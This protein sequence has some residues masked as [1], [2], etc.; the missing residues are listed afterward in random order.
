M[1]NQASLDNKYFVDKGR[2]NCP[3]CNRRH[4]V[5]KVTAVQQFN[6]T[7]TKRCTVYFVRCASCEKVS[8]HLSF[9]V[10]S[11]D[12]N[13]LLFKSDIDID[14]H[15]FYSVPTSFHVVDERIPRVLRELLTEA[16]GCLK[17]NFL[18][19]ASACAR[20]IVYEMAVLAETEGNNYEDRIKALKAKYPAVDGTYFDTLLTIQQLTS[21]KVHEESYDG[22][23]SK[24]LRLIL[25]T[26]I[27]VMNEVYVIPAVREEKRREILKL[28]QDV[29]ARENV[30][31]VA[32][33]AANEGGASAPENVA[34]NS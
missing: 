2:Y 8:M 26:L 32:T 29:F 5:F 33:A 18:T 34:D 25:A 30:R 31:T 19:G 9:T 20:K 14:E 28:K 27:E 15:L 7:D 10:L 23:Q 21:D 12:Y 17:S 4:V 6:W 24:H 3:F 13:P 16:E 22:W 11:E 1:A